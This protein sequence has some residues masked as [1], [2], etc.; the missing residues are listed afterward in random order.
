M[1]G[2]R[3]R[4][5]DWGILTVGVFLFLFAIVPCSEAEIVKGKVISA[6]RDRIEMDIGSAEGLELE[7]VGRIF[8]T[9]ML[10]GKDTPIFVGKFKITGVSEKSSR[11]QIVD[12]TGEI[13]VGY[14]V[15]VSIRTGE[16]AVSSEPSGA[17]MFLDGKEA[18][19][20]P[21][22]SGKIRPG[23]HQ[24]RL[25]LEGFDPYEAVE[26]VGAERRTVAV[27]M[28]PRVREGSIAV[29][30][31]PGGSSVYLDGRLVGQT[32][33]ERKNLPAKSYKVRVTKEGC[34]DWEKEVD[35]EA[36]KKTEV[37]AELKAKEGTL[38]IQS[39][40]PGAKV[41][42][43]G[44]EMGATPLS[45]SVKVGNYLV[46]VFREGYEVH[47]EW[48]QAAAGR[49]AVTV[50][51]KRI[52]G[53]LT[54]Q[55]DPPGA[56]IYLDGK[57]AGTGK[58]EGK[59][60][61]PKVY[62]VRVVRE[63]YED[64]E[65]DVLVEEGKKVELLTVLRARAKEA[66][67]PAPPAEPAK[68]REPQE[69]KVEREIKRTDLPEF[70]KD[71]YT[72]MEFVLVQGG[73]FEMGNPFAE[74]EEDE[75]PPHEVCVDDFYL[76]KYETSQDEFKKTMGYN[77]SSFPAG[78]TIAYKDYYGVGI[79]YPAE[80]ISWKDTQDFIKKFRQGRGKDFRLPTEAEWEYAARDGGVKA[81]WA[82]A[83]TEKE[84]DD[85]AWY[86]KNAKGTTNEVGKKKANNSGLFDM[87]GNV[88][89]WV[90]DWYEKDYYK[91]SPKKNPKGPSAGAVRVLRGGA[92]DSSAAQLR[93]FKRFYAPPNESDSK[94]GFRLAFSPPAK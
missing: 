57:V 27:K 82:G 2:E 34:E 22:L 21:F 80:G 67:K 26:E 71:S 45:L 19:K 93:V 49:K 7:D 36:E 1:I 18:G 77:P 42:L 4:G 66:A 38:E 3:A 59:G 86:S 20:T 24:V 17:T 94:T 48:V 69:K 10:E 23:R 60:L 76:A 53:D 72:G 54:V 70:W 6:Q 5:L 74:G 62:R 46:R 47:E 61:T 35:V 40:P 64:W 58:F 68:P 65:R 9:I 32:P 16:L 91:K 85:C 44:K 56:I 55:A 52:L 30:S 37:Y 84:I 8:Y 25:E 75:K 28:K 13:R 43:N 29:L 50:S 12:R 92:W 51:L 33:F 78:P 14:G 81:R 31:E 90:E 83:N 87:S 63:G 89:E 39:T 41:W 88:R 11:A 15:E 73:C 79:K